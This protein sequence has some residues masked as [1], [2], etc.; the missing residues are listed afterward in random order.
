MAITNATTSKVALMTDTVQEIMRTEVRPQFQRS[1]MEFNEFFSK[2]A[3]S[4]N[5]RGYQVPV[6]LEPESSH[7]WFPE[8]GVFP[9]AGTDKDRKMIAFITRYAKAFEWSGDM[10]AFDKPGSKALIRIK[11]RLKRL[12]TN[13]MVEF[14]Q[15]FYGDG[16]GT[17]AVVAPNDG[18]TGHGAITGGA[19]GTL[20]GAVT[21]AAGRGFMT[22]GM[23]QL[24]V[25]SR[26]N[27]VDPSTGNLRA[28]ADG[29]TVFTVTA[30]SGSQAT[31][32]YIP[33]GT[34]GES[35]VAAGDL[36]VHNGSYN[37]A[38]HGL[39]YHIVQTTGKYQELY[40][41]GHPTDA[42]ENYSQL[43]ARVYNAQGA[44]LTFGLMNYIE[45]VAGYRL[46]DADNVNGEVKIIT[47]ATQYSKARQMGNNLTRY[48][49][50]ETT[51]TLGFD[52]V[53]TALGGLWEKRRWC[54][55][56][57]VYFIHKPSF[58]K[59]EAM[60]LD[61]V[62]N[63]NGGNMVLA[64]TTLGG[65]RRDAYYGVIGWRGEFVGLEPRNN[66]A[67]INLELSGIRSFQNS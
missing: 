10:M 15:L 22:F 19:A 47:S 30:K 64:T 51:L 65:G 6:Y 60:P 45:E 61:Y 34:G 26:I 21:F 24:E 32:D 54:P 66:A 49:A 1:A 37:K 67:I 56:G 2:Q 8:A 40:R 41:T 38:Y 55:E 36:I 31:F 7:T 20:Y 13:I 27:F 25:G 62:D 52:K 44:P 58:V 39:E 9:E 28:K 23:D 11:D 50:G 5:S 43:K 46:D 53:R 17:K 18:V 59:V 12:R 48:T 4:I 29:T 42:T 14:S 16:S 57:N 35:T 3:E 63:G 33:D